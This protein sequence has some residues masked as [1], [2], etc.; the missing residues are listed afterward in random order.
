MS[1]IAYTKSIPTDDQTSKFLIEHGYHSEDTIK[2]FKKFK[3]YETW[4]NAD[5]FVI[6]DDRS[7]SNYT[8]IS[9]VFAFNENYFTH[10]VMTTTHRKMTQGLLDLFN[11]L[12]QVLSYFIKRNWEEEKDFN[13]VYS[14]LVVDLMH[15]SVVNTETVN[16]RAKIV[17]IKPQDQYIVMLLTG[18]K[19]GNSV[20][21]GLMAR[22]LSQMFRRIRTVYYN[23]RLI[24]F[25]HHEDVQRYMIE[26]DIENK[27]ND[28]FHSNNIFCG[29]SDV[30]DDLLELSNAYIQA[31]LALKESDSNYQNG[32]VVWEDAPKWSNIALFNTI[33]ASS[34]LDKRSQNEKLWRSSKFGKMLIDL[35]YSDLEKNTNNLQ[36]LHSFLI[37]ERRAT[38]TANCL[39]MHR[40]N[41]VYRISR[42]EEILNVSLEDKM[43][44][45]N[46][47]VSFLMLKA[48]GIIQKND[49]SLL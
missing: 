48:S 24:L 47:K 49:K 43:T 29:I 16:E 21:P 5:G 20:F 36:V 32:Y 23:C 35:H 9:K 26:Q 11:L 31:E 1:L 42:I 2:K 39:H 30:Y 12:I 40:N 28:Y 33:F 7:I 15:G 19:R 34:M 37:N 13:H 22:E 3:R 18:G 45:L 46:L 44:R 10:V 6:S 27:L 38:E 8:V 41:V 14:S 25:L 17:G 4:M